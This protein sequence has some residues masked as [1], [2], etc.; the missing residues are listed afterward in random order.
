M[1][2]FWSNYSYSNVFGHLGSPPHTGLAYSRTCC[3]NV[4]YTFTKTSQG[5]PAFEMMDLMWTSHYRSE[6]I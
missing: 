2:Y 4:K 3:I 5:R 6:E 1:T